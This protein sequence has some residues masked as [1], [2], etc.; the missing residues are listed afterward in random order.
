MVGEDDGL[1]R[2]PAKVGDV[3]MNAWRL[4]NVWLRG[5]RCVDFPWVSD[6]DLENF[7]GRGRFG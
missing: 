4:T 6:G 3:N 7:A 1:K 5:I 2:L